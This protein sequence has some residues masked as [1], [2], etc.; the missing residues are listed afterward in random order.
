MPEIKV[1]HSVLVTGV[2]S[3]LLSATLPLRHGSDLHGVR[4]DSN[5]RL[6]D[7]SWLKYL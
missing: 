6:A 3:N 1:D 7:L 5:L 4:Q 2:T